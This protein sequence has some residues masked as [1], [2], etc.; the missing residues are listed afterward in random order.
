MDGGM[1]YDAATLWFTFIAIGLAT[2]LP[3]ASFIVLGSRVSLPSLIE[4]A[5]RYAPAAALAAV[6]APDVFV[7]GA[8]IEWLNPRVGAA[9]VVVIV[10]TRWKNPWLP[11]I[12]G[13]AAMWGL[14]LLAG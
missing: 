3:R 11:F 10:A 1:T 14:R 12:A 13:M 5:L 4:R 2:T 8:S 7:T 6:V 9:V